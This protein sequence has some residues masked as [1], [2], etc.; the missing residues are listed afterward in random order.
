MQVVTVVVVV[1]MMIIVMMGVIIANWSLRFVE[2]KNKRKYSGMGDN[3]L[4][5]DA[6][7]QRCSKS[8]SR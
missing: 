8:L 1:M 4:E 2:D 3:G 5:S 7:G 6:P